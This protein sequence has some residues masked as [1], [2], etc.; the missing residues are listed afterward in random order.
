MLI[1]VFKFFLIFL[2]VSFL[3]V[4]LSNNP[5]NVE[6][7]W[8]SYFIE[9]NL[10]GLSFIVLFLILSLLLFI[11]IFS[12]LKNIPTNY[13]HRKNKK[14][15]ELT[16]KSLDNMAE[17]LLIGDSINL[18]KNSR[19]IKKYLD[20]D[21]FSAFMLFNSSLIK[22]D[23][24][25]SLKYLKVLESIPKAKYISERGKVILFLKR[26][27]S[28]KAKD[29]LVELCT[30]YPDDLWFHD[31]LSKIYALEENW[32]LAHDS[33]D[34]LKKIPE[35]LK[36]NLADLK[37]LSGE[38][39][40]AA[41][42][43]TSK[44]VPVVKETIKFYINGSN[45]KKASEVINKTWPNLLCLELIETFMKYKLN[46]DRE[47]LKRYKLIIKVLK[48]YINEESNET[49]LSLA[50]ASYE[51]SIWGEAQNFLDQISKNER[52]QRVID[53]YLKIFNKT[54]KVRPSDLEEVVL[55]SPTWRC[56]TCGC[57][58]DV[59]KLTCDNCG[60]VGK[61][62]WSK[63][64]VTGREDENDFFKEFL[65]NPLRHFPKVKRKN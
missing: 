30:K 2:L 36:D 20:D 55:K 16:K 19:M 63:S 64:K 17:A 11:Y 35:E 38:P 58:G 4:W 46:D 61:I 40:I 57:L 39:P 27:E 33:I 14:Y 53:L 21:F 9:T 22:N 52:D 6:I 42:K 7:F 43:L 49:K 10:L 54:Q 8:K 29:I 32:K 12:S 24:D 45:L 37:V 56:M 44:S 26:N 59:W 51:A 62:V 23:L 28:I 5:G 31:K 48:K 3:V 47:V 60:S 15:L 13:K 18:E 50:F 34:K 1:K 41:Y 65:Q 25:E